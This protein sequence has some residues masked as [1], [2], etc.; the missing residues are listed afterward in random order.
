MSRGVNALLALL[1][2]IIFAGASYR[3]AALDRAY[4]REEVRIGAMPAWLV[5]PVPPLAG[6]PGP[7]DPPSPLPPLVIVQ[8]GFSASRHAMSW[9][10]RGL[11]RNGFAVLAGDFRGHGQN[12]TPFKSDALSDDIASLINYAQSRPQVDGQRVALVG[13]SMGAHAVYGYA[14]LHPEIDA[15]VPISGSAPEGSTE[16]TR[17]VLLID[18]GG[19]PERIRLMS[20]AALIRLTGHADVIPDVTYGDLRAGTARR[21]V[22]VSGNDHVTILFSEAPVREIVDWLRATWSLPA[23]PFQSAPLELAV[24]GPL[25]VV[26]GLLVFFPLAGFLAAALLGSRPPAGTPVP[27]TVWMA[28]LSVLVAGIALFGGTPLWFMP[29]IAGNE[30]ASFFLLAGALLAV[31]LRWRR[32]QAHS[33]WTGRMRAV[34]LGIAAFT[35]VY[36][37]FGTAVT[38]LFFNLMLDSQRGIWFVCVSILF[39]PLGIAVES[40]LRPGGGWRA[41]GRSLAA[42]GFLLAGLAMAIFVFGTLPPVIGLMIP[43]LAI[44]LPIIEAVAARLYAVSGSTLAS[45]VLTALFLAWIPAAIFPIG[46]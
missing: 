26:A 6:R 10:V 16:R 14:L 31:W 35:A 19:D 38:R 17:N 44:V 39:L 42:K 33:G 13:H 18:A 25:A 24:V 1:F 45:G 30:L 46:Y 11:V 28:G 12:P 32:P 34:L 37:T 15:V 4:Y 2:S 8:H 22:E 36:A 20:R 23:A 7:P 43:S 27:G 3:F 41:V 5:L 40:A 29:F 21:F 9:I